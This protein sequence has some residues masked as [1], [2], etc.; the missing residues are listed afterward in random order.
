MA[1]SSVRRPFGGTV[2]VSE[3]VGGEGSEE[4]RVGELARN[5]FGVVRV[6]PT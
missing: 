6:S 5:I 3:C 2:V 1:L 4:V